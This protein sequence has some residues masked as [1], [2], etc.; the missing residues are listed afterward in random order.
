[1]ETEFNMR[2][3]DDMIPSA[4]RS[5]LTIHLTGTKIIADKAA[6]L[7]MLREL[8]PLIL[9]G[10][11]LA[12]QDSYWNYHMRS[13]IDAMGF[14]DIEKRIPADPGKV[15]DDPAQRLALG[16]PL[17]QTITHSSNMV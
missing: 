6:E 16:N 14:K 11:E 17:A 7:E 15:L 4:R 8:T 13:I 3:T 1:M 9:Q 12:R 5:D 10:I 2:L